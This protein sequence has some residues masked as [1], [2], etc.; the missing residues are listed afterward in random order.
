[1]IRLQPYI[2]G[3]LVLALTTLFVAA[4]SAS[5]GGYFP[6]SWGWSSAGALVVLALWA[7]VADTT[8]IRRI[9]LLVV[10]LFTLLFLWTLL[11]ASWSGDAGTSVHEAQRTL[12]ALAVVATMLLVFR[13]RDAFAISAGVLV[14][15]TLVSGWRKEGS[16]AG[17]RFYPTL[18]QVA[19]SATSF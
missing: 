19:G 17:R 9:E 18:M 3:T 8:E 14:A 13:R 2:P 12:V 4:L 11:S 6:T 7:V 10:A 1:M 5:Q 15:I 16:F